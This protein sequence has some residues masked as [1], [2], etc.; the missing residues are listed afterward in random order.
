MAPRSARRT[1]RLFGLQSGPQPLLYAAPALGFGGLVVSIQK[2]PSQLLYRLFAFLYDGL[3]HCNLPQRAVHRAE[4]KRLCLRRFV[5]RLRRLD[6][7][8]R[9]SFGPISDEAD[10]ETARGRCLGRNTRLFECTCR[11][12]R[13]GLGRPQP[14]APHRCLRLCQKLAALL[15]RQ[16]RGDCQRRQRHLPRLVLSGSG[17][18]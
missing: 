13:R 4:R 11:D 7:F 10:E 9:D 14:L 16:R 17:R 6:W 1:A 5:L 8:G 18:H 12:G 2:R 15:R 3:G